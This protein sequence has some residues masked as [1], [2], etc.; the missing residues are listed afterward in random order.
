MQYR[1]IWVHVY[2][3]LSNLHISER[4]RVRCQDIFVSDVGKDTAHIVTF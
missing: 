2:V 1:F 3:S 4:M